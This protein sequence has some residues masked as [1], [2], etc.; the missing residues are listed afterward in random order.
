MERKNTMKNK[1]LATAFIFAMLIPAT[2][3]AGNAAEDPDECKGSHC[4][5]VIG[6][7]WQET[8]Y[9]WYNPSFKKYYP[10]C[11]YTI[12]Y[13]V[14]KPDGSTFNYPGSIGR[15]KCGQGIYLEELK[16]VK[17]EPSDFPGK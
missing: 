8:Q 3:Q 17:M 16:G 4:Y 14:K 2:L 9:Q 11:D 10:R 1:V 6:V 15:V 7:K 13:T 12:M 5:T